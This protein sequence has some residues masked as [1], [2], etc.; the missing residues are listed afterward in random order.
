MPAMSAPETVGKSAWVGTDREGASR[1]RRKDSFIEG[2]NH[3]LNPA[4]CKSAA[5]PAYWTMESGLRVNPKAVPGFVYPLVRV[6]RAF[7]PAFKGGRKMASAMNCEG[8]ANA[9]LTAP[10][11]A[12]TARVGD[13]G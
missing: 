9:G 7:R 2:V 4:N 6:V 1:S 12:K 5:R 10:T 3:S 8:V 11:R 13:P